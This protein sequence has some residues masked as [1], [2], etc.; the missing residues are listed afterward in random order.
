MTIF[1]PEDVAELLT[2]AS[3]DAHAARHA[4]RL[5]DEAEARAERERRDSLRGDARRVLDWAHEL[6]GAGLVPPDGVRIF[7]RAGGRE[8][9]TVSALPSGALRVMHVCSP[10]GGSNIVAA[11]EDDLVALRGELVRDVLSAIETGA[12]WGYVRSL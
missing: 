7:R 6:A 8:R 10:F 9:V 4:K 5:R 1:V 11:T 3:E 2:R 12:V